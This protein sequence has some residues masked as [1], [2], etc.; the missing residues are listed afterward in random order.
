M[1]KRYGFVAVDMDDKGHGTLRR[2]K[3]D[4][5][6]WFRDVLHS[7]GVFPGE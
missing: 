5:F 2:S 3:K 6:Y 7:G 4:S 1:A